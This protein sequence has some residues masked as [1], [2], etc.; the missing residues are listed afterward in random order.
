METNRP[1]DHVG[2]FLE[3]FREQII[4]GV[5]SP[6]AIIQAWIS[7]QPTTINQTLTPQEQIRELF[8]V[9]E[10]GTSQSKVCFYQILSQEEPEL[11]ADLELR[12]QNSRTTQTEQKWTMENSKQLDDKHT[13]VYIKTKRDTIK[14]QRELTCQ[15]MGEIEQL[16]EKTQRGRKEIDYLKTNTEQQQEDI[17]RLTAEKHE[18]DLLIKRLRLQIENVIEKLEENK[19]EAAQEKK[20]LLKMQT[21]IYQEREALEKRR[22]ELM[23]ERHKLEMVK[24]DKTKSQESKEPQ[25]PMEQ[26]KREQEITERLI[27]DSLQSLINKSKKMMLEAKQEKEQMEKNIADLKQELKR[28]KKDISQH[29]DKIEHIK[30]ILNVSTN[31]MK[32][33]KTQRA[34]E[35]QK[36]VV[37]QMESRERQEEDVDTFDTVKIKLCRIQEEMEKLWDVLEDSEQQVEVTV[38]EKQELKTESGQIED[39]TSDSKKQ[40]QDKDGSMKTTQWEPEIKAD[41]QRQKQ[42]IENKLAQIQS[43][44]DEMQKTK[45]EIKIEKENIERD[46]QLAKAEMNAMKCVRENIERQKQELDDKLQKTKKE[47]REMEVMSSEIEIKKK[48]LAKMIRMSKR[49]RGEISKMEEER[50][51]AKEDMEERQDKTEGQGME[52][53]VENRSENQFE[54]DNME[55][56]SKNEV[57]TGM[58]R[59]ILD[60]EEIRK[61][62]RRVR[63]DTEQ[64]RRDCTQEKSEIQWM[65]F[66]VKKKRRELD[67]RLEKT[68]NERDELE[69]MKVKIQQHRKEVEQKLEDTITTILTFGE[70]KACIETAAAEMNTTREE[71]VKAQRSMDQNKEEVKNYM[72]KMTSMKAQLSKWTL[73]DSPIKKTFPRK[74]SKLQEPQKETDGDAIKDQTFKI[75]IDKEGEEEE[76]TKETMSLQQSITP[77]DQH[78]REEIKEQES[79]ESEYKQTQELNFFAMD[80]KKEQNVFLQTQTEIHEETLM[81][82]DQTELLINVTEMEE[83]QKQISKLR[84]REEQMREQINIAMGNMEGNNQEIKKLIMEINELQ[85]QKPDYENGLQIT[86]RESTDVFKHEIVKY[87][88][89]VRKQESDNRVKQEIIDDVQ[90]QKQTQESR[91]NIL[92]HTEETDG[93]SDKKD[94]GSADVQQLRAEIHRTREI[95]K[96]VKLELENQAEESN[97]DKEHKDEGSEHEGLIQD[98]KQF[99]ELLKLVQ[100]TMRQ[101]QMHLN[102][103]MSNMKSMKTAAKKQNRQL[104]Q[105]LE[106]T[107]RERDEFD[108]LKIKMQRQIEVTEQKLEKIGK[109]KSTMEKIAEKTRQKS[110]DVGIIIKRTE[111]KLRQLEDLSD[112]IEA[113]KQELENSC[114]LISQK[115]ADIEKIKTEL[116]KKKDRESA[117]ESLENVKGDIKKHDRAETDTERDKIQRRMGKE[118]EEM[119]NEISRLRSEKEKLERDRKLTMDNLDQR[120]SEIKQL[121]KVVSDQV[122]QKTERQEIEMLKQQIQVEKENVRME[123]QQAEAEMHEMKHL[124][125][126]MER[127]KQELDDKVQATKREIREMEL[128]KSELE[129]KKKESE[130]IFRKNMRKIESERKWN[131]IQKEKEELRKETKKSI[132]EVDQRPEEIVTE[133]GES[134]MLEIK[135]QQQEEELAEEKQR[136]KDQ[137]IFVQVHRKNEKQR[138]ETQAVRTISKEAEK[139]HLSSKATDFSFDLQNL[140]QKIHVNLE[141]IKREMGIVENVNVR[142][143]KQREGLKALK[144]ESRTVRDNMSQIKYQIKMTFDKMTIQAKAEMDEMVHMW[145]DIQTKEQGLEIRLEEVKKERR[146]MEVLKS[147]LEI[148]MR[149][150]HEMIRKGIKKQQDAKNIWTEI[151]GEKDAL[152][153]ETQKRKKELDKRLERIIR[154]RDELEIMKLKMQRE[155]EM[156]DGKKD[157]KRSKTRW[158]NVVIEKD[159]VKEQWQLNIV[160]EHE[161]LEKLKAEL[162]KDREELNRECEKLNKEKLDLELMRSDILKQSDTLKQAI[163]D[164]K[165]QRDKLEITQSELQKKKEHAD[166][167][168]DEINRE[169]GNIKDLTLQ[170]Q[171]ERDKLENVM[172]MII[173]KQEEQELKDDEL[174]RQTQELETSRNNLLAEKEEL[175]LLRKDLNKKKE[176]VEAALTTI[177]EESE[178]VTKMKTAFYRERAMLSNDEERM[179]ELSEL[180][181][182]AEQLNSKM[183]S[184]ETLRAKLERFTETTQEVLKTKID[185]LAQHT[186][187]VQKL[188]MMLEQKQTEFEADQNKLPDFIQELKREKQG[189]ITMI[190]D[191]L[192]SRYVTEDEGTTKPVFEIRDGGELKT[193]MIPEREDQKSVHDMTSKEKLDMMKYMNLLERNRQEIEKRKDEL[194]ITMTQLK[195]EKEHISSFLE[196]INR[197]K[198]NI[199]ETVHQVQT[200]KDKVQKVMNMI[201]LKEKEL[202]LKEADIKEQVQE[203]QNSRNIVLAERDELELLRKDLNKKKEEVEATMNTISE[204]REKVNQMKSS[205]DQDRPPLEIEKEGERSALK[206]R[207]DQLLDKM[208][209]METLREKLQQ[210]KERMS[211]DMKH[212]LIRLEQN[213]EEVLKLVSVLEQKHE[214]LDKQKENMSS[215][216]EILEREREGL[217]SSLSELAIQRQE[218]ENRQ[219]Q[220]TLLETTHLV[221][222]KAELKQDREDLDRKCEKMIKEKLDLELMRSDILK[223]SDTLKQV[224]QDIKQQRDKLEITQSE[225]QKKK[226]HADSQFDEINQEKEQLYQMRTTIETEREMFLNELKRMKGE[227]S[228]LEIREDRLTRLMYSMG[229]LTAKLKKLCQRTHEDLT[230]NMNRLGQKYEDMLQ[231][232]SILEHQCVEFVQ[233]ENKMTRYCDLIKKEK[234]HVVTMTCDKAE[235]TDILKEWVVVLQSDVAIQTEDQWKP[236]RHEQDLERKVKYLKSER[237]GLLIE[238]EDEELENEQKQRL[239][240]A[241]EQDGFTDEKISK[242]DCLRKLWKDTKTERKEIDR[243]RRASNEM[244][245]NLE[246]RLKGIKQFAKKTWL[247]K[248]KEPLDRKLKQGLSKDTTS[249]CD[250]KRDHTTL[251]EKY[252]E[253]QQIKFQMLSEIE[254]LSVKEKVSRTVTTS[255]KANQTSQVD[256]TTGDATVQVTEQASAKTSQEQMWVEE[257]EADTDLSSGLLCQLQHYCYRCCCHCDACCKQVCEGDK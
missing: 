50:G 129:I 104:D 254:K 193:E 8:R 46:R 22:K 209:S 173:L 148:K 92:T 252:T 221:E 152:K 140:R 249:Q 75:P 51:H 227:Q 238:A 199:S 161:V 20:Q 34:V 135:L 9:V 72:D 4:A 65:N 230:K 42:D 105:R 2:A 165:E 64:S 164:I 124:R 78:Q 177:G 231:Q 162:K 128:L 166:S 142:L 66:Q 6:G 36:A 125:E 27:A 103:E 187:Y 139:M 35:M 153:R 233:Q 29:K 194:Q 201:V 240:S 121:K 172:N 110:E 31:T 123:K 16:L 109:V 94:T 89:R 182:K 137:T 90:K 83:V 116:R 102:E 239:E 203:L 244:R 167:Q 40:R 14:R 115:R 210:L 30:L 212:K 76:I 119:E 138:L 196:E 229:S 19:N 99:Q 184:M 45:A 242:R 95:M 219:K 80:V 226:E 39:V 118:L 176:E 141:I 21:E 106:K 98:M 71:I 159:D 190:S 248:E 28:N 79:T 146:E 256:I 5:R 59:V 53:N 225:L 228:Q 169:K 43:E 143:G 57:N 245:N 41:L 192:Q 189:L 157:Q 107:L 70:I 112:K 136:N 156:S 68:M 250:C 168:F 247:Q 58:K 243:M 17:A 220:D 197:E 10:N 241:S 236:E 147:E 211:E 160:E 180:N 74:T 44:R 60:I 86:V 3:E 134:E 122:K 13:K 198:G 222:L 24:Y 170:L 23:N 63:E 108:I 246:K 145:D 178:Q 195:D 81:D 77:E 191:M 149:E 235:Q 91:E 120:K 52:L 257:T 69:I 15:V 215:Y 7:Q 223:Q 175:E 214:A 206:I 38:G 47:I 85:S 18:Q 113:T 171:T 25:K 84:E 111:V 131:N 188:C 82:D 218:I 117:L 181:M 62:L 12:Q 232:N 55:T 251:D 101:K 67:Q 96:L 33:T 133:R 202:Y 127:Q 155:K 200:E 150:N 158:S 185:R 11:I 255:N 144:A 163:Q 179:K 205:A 88:M 73:T 204:E 126:S 87:E 132:R 208:K 26:I 114:P 183:K 54:E 151:K 216:T 207:E 224:I 100:I 48:D 237:K 213:K 56:S 253:L 174:K 154:E 61:M 32:Q 93:R 217:R 97:I 1:G 234:K 37:P 186:E 130:K 49:K